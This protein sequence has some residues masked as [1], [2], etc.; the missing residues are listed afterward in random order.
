MRNIL[1]SAAMTFALAASAGAANTAPLGA[2]AQG[3]QGAAGQFGATQVQRVCRE[4]CRDGFCRTRCYS[5]DNV[6]YYEPRR[7]RR[8]YRPDRRYYR[9]RRDYDYDYSAP[10]VQFH[11]GV[12]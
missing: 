3:L 9:E 8:A 12:R 2:N 5:D 10:G 7:Y 11:F 1:I 6:G 4:Y